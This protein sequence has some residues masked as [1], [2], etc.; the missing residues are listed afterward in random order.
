MPFKG[1]VNI[2]IPCL[3]L[4]TLNTDGNDD[5]KLNSVNNSVSLSSKLDKNVPGSFV[6]VRVYVKAFPK[7]LFTL[8]M[9]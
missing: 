4:V 2:C 5:V 7:H 3:A 9:S 6:S 1:L 8:I